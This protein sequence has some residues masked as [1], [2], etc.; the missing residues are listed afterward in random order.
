VLVV[1][2]PFTRRL[3]G[4]GVH[5]GTVSGADVCRMF[6]AAIH[7]QGVPRHL[8]TDNDPVFEA[9]RWMA[10]LRF[11]R[12]TKSRPSRMSRCPTHSSSA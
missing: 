5:G 11:W 3:V 9:L 1:M 7:S 12:S 4:I 10:N 2:D 6:N 8:S